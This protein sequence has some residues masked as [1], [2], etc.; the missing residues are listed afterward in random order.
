MILL[1]DIG[2]NPIVNGF[3]FTVNDVIILPLVLATIRIIPAALGVGS[4][5][6]HVIIS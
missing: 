2:L 4:S 3:P 6:S 5:R 1:G